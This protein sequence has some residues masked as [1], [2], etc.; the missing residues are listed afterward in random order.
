[1]AI[2]QV[3]RDFDFSKVHLA[4]PVPLN[5]GNFFTKINHTA[6]DECL[7]VY[8]PKCSTKTG[9]VTVGTKTYMDIVFTAANTNFLEWVHS[10]E[11]RLQ[12]LMFEK[13]D[14]WFSDE[15]E[16][17]DIQ[18]VFM[19]MLKVY[20][21]AQQYVMRVYL[22]Q[23]KRLAEKPPQVYDENETPK[24]LSDIR[25][26]SD[27]IAILDIQGIKFSQKCFTVNV[28]VKQLMIVDHAPAF[29]QCLIK[30][31]IIK[32]VEVDTRDMDDEPLTLRRPEEVYGGIYRNAIEKGRRA[33]QESEE[34]FRMA[35]KI[36]MEHG[37]EIDDD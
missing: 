30:P 22:Q 21:G 9:V 25:P 27:L 26:G 31:A 12:V 13:R 1:M 2:H 32:D 34:N 5:N 18:S 16:L 7:F 35:Q 14:S 3:G 19:P 17:D 6:S 33:K 29:T 20:K 28:S 10:L 11:E 8:T 4:N 36:K 37:L 23:G 15:L 24:T